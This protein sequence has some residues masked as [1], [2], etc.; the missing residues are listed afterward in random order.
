MDQLQLIAQEL[1][2][3]KTFVADWPDER[4]HRLVADSRDWDSITPVLVAWG[5]LVQLSPPGAQEAAHRLGRVLF[6][7]IYCMG[8]ERGKNTKPMPEFLVAAEVL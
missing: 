7:A 8:Y 1:D 4:R 2:S 6:E 5:N 3:Y